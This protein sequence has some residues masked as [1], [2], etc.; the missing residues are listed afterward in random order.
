MNDMA[1]GYILAADAAARSARSALPDA[2]A[3]PTRV[4]T[5]GR[6]RV[7]FAGWLHAVADR[8]TP[9]PVAARS[10]CETVS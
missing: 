3:L 7:A 2:P 5:E 10:T 9:S 4:R 8:M 6:A 1:I